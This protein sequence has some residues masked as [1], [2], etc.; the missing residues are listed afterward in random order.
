MDKRFAVN[1]RVRVAVRSSLNNLVGRNGTIIEHIPAN[2][3]GPEMFNVRLDGLTLVPE[4]PFYEF[5]LVHSDEEYCN[6]VQAG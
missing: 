2:M 4:V 6:A 3:A 5:E 1:D